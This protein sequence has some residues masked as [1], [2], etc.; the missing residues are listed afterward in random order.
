MSYGFLQY[1]FEGGGGEK[2]EEETYVLPTSSMWSSMIIDLR[3]YIKS[4]D[5]RI[6][7]FSNLFLAIL[8]YVSSGKAHS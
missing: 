2:R 4:I 1:F 3:R 5:L 7:L 8:I 6:S